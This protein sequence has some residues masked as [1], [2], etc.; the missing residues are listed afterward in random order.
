MINDLKMTDKLYETE[1][2]ERTRKTIADLII[3]RRKEDGKQ[4]FSIEYSKDLACGNYDWLIEHFD[5]GV[6]GILR[7]NKIVSI[8]YNEVL[9]HALIC[10]H[11]KNVCETN[12]IKY[13]EKMTGSENGRICR[14]EKIKKAGRTL[15]DLARRLG[16]M[17]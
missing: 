15:T 3:E 10:D 7:R 11:L 1:K 13:K 5:Y 12:N 16:A 8:E 14:I 6:V 17:K 2:E 9:E 4:L